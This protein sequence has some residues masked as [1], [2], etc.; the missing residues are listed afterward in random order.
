V[1]HV[2]PGV[3]LLT[4]E[5]LSEALALRD[6]SDE[7]HGVHAVNLLV[8]EIAT[9]LRAHYRLTPDINRGCRIVAVADNYDRLYYP[10]EGA[11]RDSRYTRYVSHDRVLRTQMTAVIP[12]ALRA[13]VPLDHD[14]LLLAPGIVYRRDSVD[15][16]HCG[17]PH[18][19]DVWL[20][21]RGHV[22]RP[23]L[24]ELIEII[25]GVALPGCGHRCNPTIHPYTVGGLEV[26][27]DVD[28]SRVEVLECG[29]IL[30]Q[31]LD[32]AGLPSSCHSGLALGMGLDRLVMLRKGLDDVRL[33]RCP[34]PRIAG[35]MMDLSPYRPVS[36][37]PA[38]RRNLSVAVAA[39][40]TPE[41]VGDR[42][43]TA[44]GGRAD[45]VEEVAVISETPYE[46]LAPLVRE[47]LGMAEGQKNLLIG[48]TI[49]DPARSIPRPE[50][51]TLAQQVYLALHEGTR[52]Y[53]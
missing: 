8:G 20:V 29:L 13:K 41:E 18:Q 32:D 43:R 4:A 45:Q 35:Q 7:A 39:D 38:I 22:G 36:R 10:P 17:E 30:A 28:G 5:Q 9:S 51:N 53:M 26:E 33:L 47:R 25:L 52:G 48:V 19:M 49:R 1:V 11:A 23:D 34:D 46:V 14:R 44:L 50:A 12:G 21:R 15:R 3:R 24:L 6:L 27:A 37:Q 31:L 16:L 40:L 2:G 42:V